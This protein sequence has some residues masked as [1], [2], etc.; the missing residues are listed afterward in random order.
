[1]RDFPCT[2]GLT[3]LLQSWWSV[4]GNIPSSHLLL[5]R[6]SVEQAELA[7]PLMTEIFGT[8]PKF[9]V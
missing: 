2:P 8:P 3:R 7:E 9:V 1:M 4:S 5:V 6:D